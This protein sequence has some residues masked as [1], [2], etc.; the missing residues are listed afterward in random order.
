MGGGHY[1]SP[2]PIHTPHLC[3]QIKPTQRAVEF[4]HQAGQHRAQLAT[5]DTTAALPSAAPSPEQWNTST[6]HPVMTIPPTSSSN[7]PPADLV[8]PWPSRIVEAQIDPILLALTTMLDFDLDFGDAGSSPPS[9]PSIPS[10]HVIP[11]TPLAASLT[12]L[13]NNANPLVLTGDA[14]SLPPS[15]PSVPSIHVIPATPLAPSLTEVAKN[16]N[17]LVLTSHADNSTGDTQNGDVPDNDIPANTTCKGLSTP[18]SGRWSVCVNSILAACY[19]DLDKILMK[20]V[21]ETSCSVQQVVD[22]WHKSR[23]RVISRTNHW[24]IWPSY[25]T[26][27][28][29]ECNRAGIPKGIPSKSC[30]W[31]MYIYY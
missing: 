26:Y 19:K 27:E 11:A 14:G 4:V 8:P 7:A 16:D 29:E 25:L 2:P 18:T 23:G 17:P 12:E 1:V 21:S 6:S 10:T 3:I 31:T 24:N 13:A 30:F 20:A 22:S 5:K 9:Q 15:Q 28:T